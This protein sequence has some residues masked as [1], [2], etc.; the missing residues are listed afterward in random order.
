[1]NKNNYEN[2]YEECE[3]LL[4]EFGLDIGDLEDYTI[5]N[6][7]KLGK[8][9]TY[10][11]VTITSIINILIGLGSGVF[12]IGFAVTM[13]IAIYLVSA[14][15]IKFSMKHVLPIVIPYKRSDIKNSLYFLD[16]SLRTSKERTLKYLKK[17]AKYKLNK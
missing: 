4:S 1:M 3:K 15:S 10:S 8:I 11:L 13:L 7:A 12:E 17:V 2:K 5:E 14:I 16:K 6:G 9:F